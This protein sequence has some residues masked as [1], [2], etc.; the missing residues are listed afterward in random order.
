MNFY[1]MY[2]LCGPIVLTHRANISTPWSWMYFY[3]RTKKN[4]AWWRFSKMTVH[5]AVSH[6]HMQP[7]SEIPKMQRSQP[8]WWPKL[9]ALKKQCHGWWTIGSFI[10][11]HCLYLILTFQQT[12]K[13]YLGNKFVKVLMQDSSLLHG[14]IDYA[15]T[16]SAAWDL[17]VLTHWV[18]HQDG[19]ITPTNLLPK[20]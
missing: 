10:E 15:R 19:V 20:Q 12:C 5:C 16:Q 8:F 7:L 6:Y 4:S 17:W 1:H 2:M 14:V 11:Q 13:Y 18:L 9:I 3:S